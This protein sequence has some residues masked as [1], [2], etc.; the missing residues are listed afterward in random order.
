MNKHSKDGRQTPAETNGVVI[1]IA[2]TK[3]ARNSFKLLCAIS[4]SFQGGGFELMLRAAVATLPPEQQVL[5]PD[6]R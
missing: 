4:Q 5:F 6:Y 2:T 3:K 1:T